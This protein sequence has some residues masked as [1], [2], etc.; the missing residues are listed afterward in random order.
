[1]KLI[2]VLLLLVGIVGI[3]L[4]AGMFG[5]IGMAGMIGSLGSLLS[6]IG[7]WISSGQVGKT[8][9]EKEG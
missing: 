7:F 8:K 1:M 3:F 2:S 9:K 5:T 4:S 6:G